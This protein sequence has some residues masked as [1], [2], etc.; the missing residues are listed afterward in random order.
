MHGWAIEVRNGAPMSYGPAAP[1]NT[2][3][4]ALYV[5][6]IL[7]DAR[8]AELPFEE[9]TEIKLAINLRTA[10]SIDASDGRLSVRRQSRLQ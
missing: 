10:R 4:A 9:P 1:E 6:R 7:K 5:D 2:V 8:I 3:R